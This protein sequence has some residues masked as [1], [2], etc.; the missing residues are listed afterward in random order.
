MMLH[1][2]VVLCGIVCM[3]QYYSISSGIVCCINVC[4][5]LKSLRTF[6]AGN[7]VLLCLRNDTLCG[8]DR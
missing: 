2:V 7:V 5:L 3:L 6:G 8:D 1:A 4:V